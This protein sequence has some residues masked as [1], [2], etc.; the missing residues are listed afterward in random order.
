M[1]TSNKDGRGRVT[2][3]TTDTFKLYRTFMGMAEEGEELRNQKIAVDEK[4]DERTRPKEIDREIDLESNCSDEDE[5]I[6]Y[7]SAT[8]LKGD[9]L[10]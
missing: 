1:K 3:S 10:Y 7:Q 2:L 4:V 6:T 5:L 8:N 9:I